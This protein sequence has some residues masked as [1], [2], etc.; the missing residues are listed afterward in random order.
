MSGDSLIIVC[1]NLL[2]CTLNV[3]ETPNV[4]GRGLFLILKPGSSSSRSGIS[5]TNTLG[6]V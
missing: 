5:S 4:A 6:I 1:V 2:A 3:S